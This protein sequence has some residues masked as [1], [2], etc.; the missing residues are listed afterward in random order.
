MKNIILLALCLSLAGCAGQPE[1]S[2]ADYV[3]PFIGTGAVQGSL[4][5]NNFPGALVP[6]GMVQLSPDTR[7]VPDWDCA[8]GYDYNDSHICGFSHTHLSGTGVADLFDVLLM[9]FTCAPKSG[10]DD[11]ASRFA[12]S[13]E[14][15]RA[16]Y[17][18]V[19]LA[20]Y[21]ISAELTTTPR[22]GFHRYTFPKDSALHLLVDLNHSRKK[23]DWGTRILD[24]QLRLVDPYTL[25]GYRLITGWVSAARKVYFQIKLSQPAIMP[26]AAQGFLLNGS[27]LSVALTFDSAKSDGGELL[28]KVALSPVSIANA[29][30]NMGELPA[31]DF[32]A[33]ASAAK[34]LWNAELGKIEVEGTAQQ[35]QIF[36]TALYHT[37]VHPNLLC[38]ADGSYARGD[39]TD[40]TTG[41]AEAHYSTF[42]LWDTYRSLH[43]LYTLL[44]PKRNADMVR[45]LLRGYENYG[46]LPIWQLWGQE[47][48]CMIGNHAIPVVVDA[49]L[50]NAAGLDKE[51]AY[52]AVRNSSLRSHQNSPFEL[53]EK[54]GYM[55]ENLQSQS[56][57]ITL[58]MAYDDWCVAQL[59]Q[60]LGKGDDYR[61]FS[62]RSAF[63]KNLFNPQTKFFQSKDDSGA[64][65]QPF[66]PYKYGANGGYPFT[67]GNAWQ[68]FWYVP[69]AVDTLIAMVGG[70]DVFCAKLDT[71]FRSNIHE[72]LNSNASGFIGQYAHG[73]EP[74]HHVPYLYAMA[75]QPRKTQQHVQQIMRTL[76]NTS[77][78]GYAGNED[79]GA[80]SAWYVWSALGFYPVNPADGRYIIGAPLHD[81]ATL[82]LPNGKT[83][84]VLARRSSPQD[85]Y[86]QKI[87]LNGNDY[88]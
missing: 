56:V 19:E 59:A 30:R 17:Y 53:W 4:S 46:F 14:S 81:K 58:E 74:S 69:H 28:V 26:S 39:M 88:N 32:D 75:G 34:A 1:F 6:W 62:R 45:S 35:K 22:V 68:Y 36:Y 33:T 23:G 63:Y 5:G 55:P 52:D 80:M 84:S 57:S 61:Y 12:H 43:P 44:H 73:N 87:R 54:Y 82:R 8:S 41:N 15:A 18:Q 67:E 60:H 86:V 65:M 10:S 40:A 70:S 37:M 27:K 20:D 38:D 83:F 64:W 29:R 21:G 51:I 48:Y 77:S 3:N 31:W 11:Y 85:T 9:P 78:S 49:A 47:N 25:E 42:S 7:H 16:G 13:R 76:Y 71:F 24:A 2:P 79:C 72:G 66:D 50:K